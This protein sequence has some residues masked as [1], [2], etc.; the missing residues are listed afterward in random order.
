[1]KLNKV[2]TISPQSISISYQDDPSARRGKLAPYKPE[3]Y[4]P[5]HAC[6]PLIIPA[7]NYMHYMF[8]FWRLLGWAMLRA[9]MGL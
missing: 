5:D 6:Q 9:R 1:M 4:S 2:D 3:L 7:G 8:S